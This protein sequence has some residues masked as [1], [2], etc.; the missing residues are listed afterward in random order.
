[1]KCPKCES[2]NTQRLEV[3][4]QSGTLNVSTSTNST[5]IGFSGGRLGIAGGVS[6]TSGQTQSALAVVCSPPVI[7]PT[8]ALKW[9]IAACVYGILSGISMQWWVVSL[10]NVALAVFCVHRHRS[11]SKF[12]S[13]EW[14]PLYRY[15]S[16]SWIC[17][18]CGSN[19]HHA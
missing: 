4:Y 14:P 7:K 17:H 5:G 6:T 11:N 1:M 18:K 2:E 13:T 9:A 12:N 15:W 16:E 10:I 3:A 19:Y 8:K